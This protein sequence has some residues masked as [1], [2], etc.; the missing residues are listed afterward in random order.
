MKYEYLVL[1]L[2]VLPTLGFASRIFIK[3]QRETA[4]YYS[5]LI[6]VVLNLLI[7]ALLGVVYFGAPVTVYEGPV[8]YHAVESEFTIRLLLDTVSGI[9]LTVSTLLYGLTLVYSRRYLHRE[10][11]YGRFFA[12]MASFYVG[13]TVVILAGNLELLFVGWEILGVTSFFLIAFYRERYLPVKNAMKVFSI[14]R[15]A[16]ICLLLGIWVCHHYFGKSIHLEDI[17]AEGAGQSH[18][19]GSHFFE[20]FIPLVFIVAAMVKSGQFPFS[21]WVPRAME[22][23]TSSSAIFYGAISTHIG[24]FLLIRTHELW[25]HN[26]LMPWL[27][28]A[29][30]LVTF[31]VASSI[32]RV[33]PMIKTQIGYAS[34]A[35]IGL[36]FV[37]VAAGLW[38]LALIHFACNAGLRTYQL[39]VSPAVVGYRIR[40]MFFGMGATRNKPALTGSFA[41][42]IGATL[43]V[44]GVREFG[45]DG[46]VARTLWAPLKRLGRLFNFLE[47]RTAYMFALP[48]FAIGLY[49]VYHKEFLPEVVLSYLPEVFAGLGLVFVLMAFVQRGSALNAWTMVVINQLYQSLAFGF[50]DEFDFNQVHIYLSGIL[51]CAAV[52]AWVLQRLSRRGAEVR[53]DGWHGNALEYPRLALIF[54]L[55]ALGIAGFP[56]TPTFIGEDLMLGHVTENQVMLLLLLVP[57]IILDALAVMRIYARVFLGPHA[58]GYHVRA[59]KSA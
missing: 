33:Q 4:V 5:S 41:S 6:P 45:L 16:D 24:V 29:V 46:L 47:G 18:M 23:P 50:N 15:L 42:R 1:A 51:V 58:A 17:P 39:L 27:I 20:W 57:S 37:E 11:G 40:E 3:G 32:S 25:S 53:L 48:P 10:P 54:V 38:W 49:A 28:G 26:P 2:L 35:Q 13:L 30:G 36:M 52:G 31:F 7:L 19:V 8:L 22:G 12:N 14:Y 21:T 43:Y 55:A 44:L 34:V 9:F 56:I 59:P